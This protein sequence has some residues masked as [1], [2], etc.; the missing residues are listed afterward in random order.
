MRITGWIAAALIAVAGMDAL[1]SGMLIPKDTS[2]PPLAIKYQRVDI[3]IKD[4]VAT[5]RMEQVFKNNENRDLEAI[6]VFPLPENASIS[7]FAMYMNGKRVSGE[8]VEKDKARSVYQ[9]IVRRIRD[10]GLLEYIGGNLFRVSVFPVPKLGEQKIELTYSQQLEFE[11]GLFRFVYPLRTGE[12][13]TA[14]L[15]DFTVSARIASSVPIRNVYSPSHQVGISKKSE[16]EA[17]IGFEETRSIL[18]KDF[19]LYYGASKKDFGLNLLTHGVK[20]QDGF[21]MMMIAPTVTPPR[22]EVVRRDVT[23]AFD[24]SGSMAGEKIRQAREALKYCLEKLNPGDRFNVVR[25]STDV[26]PLHDGL[27]EASQDNVRKAVEF[28]E[29]M[30]ARGGTAIDAALKA[31]LSAKA[32]DKRQR[33]VVFLTDGQPTIGVTDLTEILENLRKNADDRTRIFVFGVG[34]NV[35]THLL[36]RISGEHGGVSQYVDPK[37]N[38]EVKV[39]SFY[40]KISMPVLAHPKVVLEKLKVREIHPGT[41][42]DLFAGG[43]I[44][45]LGHYEGSG[46]YAI[47][48]TG[49]INGKPVEFVYEGTFPKENADNEFIPRIWATRRVGY[50]LDQIRLKGEDKELKDEVLRLSKEYGIMTPYTSYLV[51]E[52]DKDYA[53]HGITRTPVAIP[54]AATTP[55]TETPKFDAGAFWGGTERRKGERAREGAPGAASAPAPTAVV[56]VFEPEKAADLAAAVGKPV[57]MARPRIEGADKKALHDYFEAKDGAKAVDFSRG[58]RRY[59][60]R[61]SAAD[62]AVQTIRHVGKKTFYLI[63][64]VWVDRDYKKEMKSATLQYASEEYFKTVAERPELKKYLALGSKVVVVLDDGTAIIVREE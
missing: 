34:D 17:V 39:S 4:G 22:D 12:K 3:R 31:A 43:Q 56:P 15:E 32:D 33:V 8:L 19:V 54:P 10:P 61:Q 9:E 47:R 30:E 44:T 16:N 20:G 57:A 13:A 63:D 27:L 28:A 11:A 55:P 36:D 59:E 21:F 45:I 64:G 51:L 40:D 29:K 38:I 2:L 46:D 23:F 18:D 58:I 60:E 26:E 42:P 48:L 5:A 14:T 6:Y 53:A 49:E 41:L 24:T 37:E 1:G 62:E 35:N 7:D 25:F 50:L 52:G